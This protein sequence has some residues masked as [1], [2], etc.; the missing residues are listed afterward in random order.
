MPSWYSMSHPH[1]QRRRRIFILLG[2]LLL[3]LALASGFYLGQRAAYGGMGVDPQAYRELQAALP[4]AREEL[5]AKAAELEVETTRHAVDREALEMVRKE[6]AGQKEQIAGLEEGLRFY[7]SLMSPGEVSQGL[8]LR[9]IELVALEEAGRYSYRIV[10]QQEA[11]KHEL[12]K[13]KLDVEVFG[14]LGQEQVSYPLSE[15]SSDTG[16]EAL[17]LRFRYF[18]AIEGEMILPEGFEPRGIRA[19]ASTSAP[20]K[21]E[22]RA[23]FPW[24]VQERFTHVG[25]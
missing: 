17:A 20:R 11:R 4:L 13:G 6:I 2:G 10:A 7:R 8:S 19:V 23:E 5:K 24:Q 15:L 14:L 9:A 12:L 18:Q 25:K 21:T 22:V 16:D 3:C 1:R